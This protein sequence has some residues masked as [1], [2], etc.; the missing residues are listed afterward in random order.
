MHTKPSAEV[1]ANIRAEMARRGLSQ[2]ELAS[3][4][5]IGQSALSKRLAGTVALDVNEL[6]AVAG[7]LHVDVSVLLTGAV[8][9]QVS[10]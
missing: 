9:E 1:G 5:G 10:A 3:R 2:T 6:A 7:F 4:M 8:V